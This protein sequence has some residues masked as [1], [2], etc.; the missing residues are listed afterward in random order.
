MGK[1]A[2]FISMLLVLGLAFSA[3]F[4]PDPYMYEDEKGL[5]VEYIAFQS[6]YANN[7]TAKIMKIGDKE[8]LLLLDGKIVEDSA[9]IGEIVREYYRASFYPSPAEL[10]AIKTDVDKFHASRNYSTRFGPSEHVCWTSGTFLAHR[11]CNDLVSCT[12]TASM[13]CTITGADGCLIDVLATYILDYKKGIDKLNDGYGRFNTEYNSFGTNNIASSFSNM[14]SALDGLRAGA[15]QVSKNKLRY[16][17]SCRDCLLVCPEIKLDY[18]ALASAKTKIEALRIKTGPYVN[19]QTTID[20][21]HFSTQERILYRAGEEQAMVFAPKYEAAKAKFGGLSAQA[22]EAKA[23]VSDSDFVSAADSFLDKQDELEHKLM[24][25]QFDGF[26]AIISGYETAGKTL[27]AKINGSAAPYQMMMDAQDEANDKII[28][29]MWSTNR[30]SKSS[31]D[32]YNSLAE[33]KIAIDAKIAPPMKSEQYAAI[34]DDYQKLT[35]DTKTYIASSATLQDSVFG[36]GNSFGRA[37]VDGT[38]ALVSSMT[39]ISFKT[40]QEVAKYAPPLVLGAI[41]LSILTIGLLAFV[42]VFYHFHGFF[43]SKLALSGWVL[44]FLGFVFVLLIGSVGFYGIVVAN[45]KYTS[46]VDYYGSLRASDSRVAIIV[47]ETG[48][49]NPGAISMRACAD[50]VAD[51]LRKINKTMVHKYY[52]NG[53]ACIAVVPK[54]MTEDGTVL[55]ETK[56]DL[57]AP[58]CLNSMPDMPVIELEHS[59]SNQPPIFTTIVTKQAVFRGNDAYYGK[60]P[61]CDPAN[62]LD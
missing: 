5:V 50:Q 20:N 27:F 6:Q 24:L 43:R 37:S 13:V 45:E 31:L 39:P 14:D 36:M 15:D 62:V 10:S 38:M 21:L 28:V 25:R 58:E 11:P 49:S 53:K 30:L 16:D 42:A 23:L 61:L 17:T 2:V 3:T 40:R 59:D 57:K 12:Q 35:I 8:A 47:D 29:A 52:I 9:T 56:N 32:A 55:Y 1:M 26:D 19:L 51:Q 44:A 22:V 7:S 54:N 46:F 34:A 48:S 4:S 41:D 60:K 18:A 33:R